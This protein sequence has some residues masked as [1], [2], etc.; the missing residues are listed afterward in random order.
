MTT[1]DSALNAAVPPAAQPATPPV[2]AAP[3]LVSPRMRRYALFLLFCAYTINYVDRQVITI[4]QDPIKAELGLTDTQLGLMTGLSFALFY[5]VLGVPIA[6]LADRHSR[7]MIITIS[8][9]LWSAMTALCATAGS[10]TT[11]L[12][13]R[14][15]VGVGEAGL[16]PPAHS[17]LSDYYEPEKRAAALSIYSSAGTV[18]MMI[19]LLAGGLI[20]QY[21]GWRPAI[22]IVG[23]PG[24]LLALITWTTLKEPR[25]G[26]YDDPALEIAAASRDGL[27]DG[28]ATLARNPAFVCLML[29]C[30]FHTFVNYGIGNWTA[31]FL[32]RIHGLSSAQIGIWLAV[33]AVGPGLIGMIGTGYIADWLSRTRPHARLEVAAAAM[34][35]SIPFQTGAL[36]ATDATG[37]LLILSGSFVT[38]GAYLGP[39][40]AAA[41]AL[42]PPSLR[43]SASAMIMLGVNLIG[44]GLGPLAVGLLSDLWAGAGDNALRYAMLAI[45]PGEI[46]AFLFI[47][48]TIARAKRLK[49]TADHI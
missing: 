30:G 31:P 42:V 36:L 41:H 28:L 22:W 24:L 26:Q 8:M 34:I 15:G 25:R 44:L 45:V 12:L 43:A 33:L 10:F 38:A 27:W 11:L 23:L 39:C 21:F 47:A 14:I 17:L 40:I 37:A 5:A 49:A 7:T 29:G 13:Y 19:G 20:N 4:L 35:L 48:A 1:P 46:V 3:P 2:D 9:T 32:G 6:R 16:T 18:G